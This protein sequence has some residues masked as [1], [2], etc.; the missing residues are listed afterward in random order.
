M[1]VE[2]LLFVF[3]VLLGLPPVLVGPFVAD[4][5]L[6]CGNVGGGVWGCSL[7]VIIDVWGGSGAIIVDDVDAEGAG[8]VAAT[9]LVFVVVVSAGAGDDDDEAAAAGG[10]DEFE[11]DE[12]F[13]L[14]FRGW[15]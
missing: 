3:E 10:C 11:F 15:Y 5:E 8:A 13:L 12:L 14:R 9:V 2:L 7:V 4:D 6:A 1:V